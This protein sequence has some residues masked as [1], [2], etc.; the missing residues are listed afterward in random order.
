MFPCPPLPSTPFTDH[1][2]PGKISNADAQV[3]RKVSPR[4]FLLGLAI[5]QAFP[6]PNFNFAVYLGALA[7]SGTSTSPGGGAGAALGA[8]IGYIAIFTPGLALHT[9]TMGVWRVLRRYRAATSAIRGI[10]AAAVGLVFTAVYRLWQIGYLGVG[11][12]NGSPLGGDAWWVVVTATS[13]VGGR[14][15]GVEAPV[16]ILLGGVMGMVWYGVVRH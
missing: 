6:G 9:A 3:S 2:I 14:W 5:I 10:N 7:V 12:Q 11:F 16:A 13:F 8:V 15:F 4:N 1:P